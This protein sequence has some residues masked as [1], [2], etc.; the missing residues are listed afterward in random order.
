MARSTDDAIYHALPITDDALAN[1]GVEI[2]RAGLIDDELFV[3]AR[4]AFK[5]PA[6]WGEVL[7]DITRRLAQIYSLETDL[8][9]AEALAEIEEAYAADLGAKAMPKTP[10]RRTA[11]PKKVAPKTSAPAKK[12]PARTNAARPAA[13]KPRAASAKATKPVAKKPAP[14][15][16]AKR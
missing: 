2:L 13:A 15:P 3:T 11:V 5:D 12:P 10:A 6:T 16:R 4:H 7:A 1:G 9:E 8:T 14:R